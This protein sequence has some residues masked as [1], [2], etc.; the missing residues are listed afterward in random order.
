MSFDAAVSD[1]ECSG[2]VSWRLSTDRGA[3]GR[4]EGDPVSRKILRSMVGQ[5][6]L[7]RLA[8]TKH[9]R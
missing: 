7:A 6:L 2:L 4:L 9:K 1:L 3:H 5:S 8:S